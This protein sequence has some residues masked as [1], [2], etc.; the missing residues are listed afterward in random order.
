[1]LAPAARLISRQ[2]PHDCGRRRVCTQ[3]RKVSDCNCANNRVA[4]VAGLDLP[5][6]TLTTAGPQT[7]RLVERKPVRSG[8]LVF[9]QTSRE[10]I[11]VDIAAVRK[12]LSD[13]AQAIDGMLAHEC[14]GPMLSTA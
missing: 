13:A 1:M 5:P 3:R 9:L 7:E 2:L 10:P 4:L 11:A 8:Y 14:N 6:T 12:M